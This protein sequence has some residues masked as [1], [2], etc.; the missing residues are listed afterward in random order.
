MKFTPHAA[1]GYTVIHCLFEPGDT[2]E[3]V[4]GDDGLVTS[5]LY[6]YTHGAAKVS[7]K[8]TSEQLADRTAGWLNSEH[9]D[10][11]ASTTGTL[12]LSFEEPTE[13]ICIPHR[14]NPLG[15]PS[16]TPVCFDAGKNITLTSGTD[17]FLAKGSLE[18]NTKVFVGPCQIRVRSGESIA[19]GLEKVYGLIMV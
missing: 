19:N 2:R 11:H 14:H 8:E 12:V 7:V 3:V 16:V 18:I 5:G 10:A 15:L 13:W 6:Y 1:F 17:L 4:L 9:P